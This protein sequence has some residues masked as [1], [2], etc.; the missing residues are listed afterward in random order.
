[1]DIANLKIDCSKDNGVLCKIYF[2]EEVNNPKPVF[3]KPVSKEKF[4]EFIKNYPN[5][6]EKDYYM[7]WFSWNDDVGWII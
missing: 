2:N 1:M 3:M 4:E 6:L 7:D 5:K